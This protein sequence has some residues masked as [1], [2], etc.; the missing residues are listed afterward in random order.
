MTQ[1]QRHRSIL[2]YLEKEGELIVENA[3]LLFEASPATIRRDFN[4][5]AEQAL[6]DKTWG[7]IIK[8]SQYTVENSMLPLAYRQA[9]A[10]AE[11]LKIAEK[12]ALLVQDGDVVMI[13][14]G[15]TTFQMAS[16]LANK[17]IRIITNSILIA[18][19]IDKDKIEK[20]GAEVFLT[21]GMLY[22]ESGLLVGP[23]A[24]Q[25]IKFY[26]AKW[27]FLS[28]GAL[29]EEG[30]S[31]SNQLVVE[32]EQAIISQSDIIVL[33]ADHSKF[34]KRNMCK[35]CN[36]SDLNYII[37]NQSEENHYYYNLENVKAKI[38]LV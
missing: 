24:N 2:A 33:L 28:C 34:G 12:A 31:N 26:N 6:A 7:G 11:K 14:G 13:D 19:Q 37:T 15:S 29:D 30:P 1:G 17:R 8:K 16:F 35:L 21:G 10:T 23:Q 4:D 18:Y 3:S 22:P 38:M 20:K 5:L 32:S 36:W 25:N 9:Q 27:A